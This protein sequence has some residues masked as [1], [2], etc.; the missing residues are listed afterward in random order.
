MLYTKS[1]TKEFVLS[2]IELPACVETIYGMITTT[3]EQKRLHYVLGYSLAN[4]LYN[5]SKT[6]AITRMTLND[7]C[8]WQNL[9]KLLT[10]CWARVHHLS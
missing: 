9:I 8:E 2:M 10:I 3:E 7:N 5:D 6:Y 1:E 4:I